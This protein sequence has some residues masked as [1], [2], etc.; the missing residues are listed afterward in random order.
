MPGR[1]E[2]MSGRERGNA[3]RSEGNVPDSLSAG[4]SDPAR[5][6][7]MASDPILSLMDRVNQFQRR[8]AQSTPG[9]GHD[10][11]PPTSSEHSEEGASRHPEKAGEEM[12][13]SA[14]LSARKMKKHYG[15]LA[16][17]LLER[18]R[19]MQQGHA[20]DP[21]IASRLEALA[22]IRDLV[23]HLHREAPRFITSRDENMHEVLHDV[24]KACFTM[25]LEL[26]EEPPPPPPADSVDP[27]YRMDTAVLRRMADYLIRHRRFPA[28]FMDPEA[29]YL[30]RLRKALTLALIDY[31]ER[32]E[33]HRRKCCP[34]PE[35]FNKRFE[36]F[37]RLTLIPIL[38]PPLEEACRGLPEH[39]P[40]IQRILG[41]VQEL[42]GIPGQPSG[43]LKNAVNESE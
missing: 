29:L 41:L 39:A 40:H 35:A 36:D 31:G 32:L 17:L 38:V 26:Q 2:T 9:G 3:D 24:S 19:E 22:H 27:G 18:Y 14:A 16:A 21:H 20:T 30:K 23:R 25:T 6:N 1:S 13:S 37:M 8:M 7:G 11:R 12:S 4:I 28:L 42:G 33:A 5:A 43:S 34:E 10:E 15:A